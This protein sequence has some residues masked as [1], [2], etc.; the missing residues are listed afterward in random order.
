V[1]KR[2]ESGYPKGEHRIGQSVNQRFLMRSA[3]H[4]SN[5]RVDWLID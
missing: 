1:A 3:K 2:L 4:G 5:V